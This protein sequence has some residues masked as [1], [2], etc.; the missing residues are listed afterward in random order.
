MKRRNVSPLYLRYSV[1]D[2]RVVLENRFRWLP[3]L[4]RTFI[5]IR[6]ALR[7]RITGQNGWLLMTDFYF[8]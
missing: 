4:N 7:R 5:V 1:K 3:T 6:F 2:N 8:I